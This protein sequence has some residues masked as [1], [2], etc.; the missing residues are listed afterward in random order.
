[1]E[2]RGEGGREV[3]EGDGPRTPGGQTTEG[4]RESRG[5]ERGVS[6]LLVTHSRGI[7]ALLGVLT[8]RVRA[9]VA[10]TSAGQSYPRRQMTF[11]PVVFPFVSSS[12]SSSSFFLLRRAGQKAKWGKR[13]DIS[14]NL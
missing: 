2:S 13:I 14:G 7:C 6:W 10:E 3:K 8:C 1:M 12:S 11:R 4:G 9:R 5:K